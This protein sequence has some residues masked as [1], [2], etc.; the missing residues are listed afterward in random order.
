MGETGGTLSQK[1]ERDTRSVLGPERPVRSRARNAEEKR[2]TQGR[3]NLR[4]L[5][6]PKKER[7]YKRRHGDMPLRQCQNKTESQFL[8]TA[9]ERGSVTEEGRRRGRRP[10]APRRSDELRGRE[11]WW[12]PFGGLGSFH[13]ILRGFVLVFSPEMAAW[14]RLSAVPT[15]RAGTE[16]GQFPRPGAI[17]LHITPAVENVGDR[18]KTSRARPGRWKAG[19]R[20]ATAAHQVDA[21]CLVS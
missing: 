10:R 18:T 17:R 16:D 6:A 19:Q 14:N 4:L 13:V 12:K 20:R 15:T 21:V 7:G 5:R 9:A 3:S 8:A 2:T 11:F 1:R